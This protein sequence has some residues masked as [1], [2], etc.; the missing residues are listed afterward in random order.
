MTFTWRPV[1]CFNWSP[2]RKE[3][4]SVFL[5][6]ST[7]IPIREVKHKEKKKSNDKSSIFYHF[8][9]EPGT[10]IRETW[11]WNDTNKDIFIRRQTW[12][13]RMSLSSI[14]YASNEQIPSIVSIFNTC[15]F[16]KLSLFGEP[17][18]EHEFERTRD[19]EGMSQIRTYWNCFIQTIRSGK[20]PNV[21]GDQNAVRVTP[22][23]T[24]QRR[25]DCCW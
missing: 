14:E 7:F 20:T 4:Q 17:W 1:D 12:N 21:H 23:H 10:P 25:E 2:P 3:F 6:R 22:S 19:W 11:Y 24:Q 16:V 13:H 8:F 18:L 15:S 9:A 5:N